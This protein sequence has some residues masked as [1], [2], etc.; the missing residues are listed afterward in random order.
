MSDAGYSAGVR[1]WG[2]V[3]CIHRI[4]LRMHMGQGSDVSSPVRL[5]YTVTVRHQGCRYSR[6]WSFPKLRA[7]VSVWCLGRCTGL[8]GFWLELGFGSELRVNAIFCLSIR[9]WWG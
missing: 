3:S 2:S 6:Y 5:N 9:I 4:G 8:I 1:V 7:M